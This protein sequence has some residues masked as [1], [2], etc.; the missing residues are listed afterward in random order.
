MNIFIQ[1]IKVLVL[2]LINFLYFQNSLFAQVGG[3]KETGN[4]NEL[5]LISDT[6][7]YLD[8]SEEGTNNSE[9]I[10]T[11][12]GE[13]NVN[14]QGVLTY[15]VP[16]EV[17]KGINDFQPNIALSYNSQAG[18]GQ[19]GMG[20]NI[21][22]LS[23]ITIGG[24][25]NRIDGINEGVQYNG[26]D[27]Y[28]L[29]GQRLIQVGTSNEYKTEQYSQIKITKTDANTFKIQYTDGKVAIYKLKSLGQYLIDNIQ[30]AYGNK[31][32]YTYTVTTNVA[33]LSTIK[34]GGSNTANSPF[35]ISFVYNNRS[36]PVKI[37]RNGIEINNSK[38]L[39]EI[40]VSSTS[41]GVHRKYILTHVLTSAKIER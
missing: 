16:I 17:Y 5:K 7:G 37:F 4:P 38:F 10:P 30:D 25:S 13:L 32:F 40:Q 9:V 34:Y 29:D 3:F 26:T 39:K 19:A 28:Y 36:V 14:E 6:S 41:L 18:N 2:I 15:T 35:T 8:F 24:K 22:G 12:K 33:Y 27:P 1:R 11:V 31:I 23:S 21:V 20:W